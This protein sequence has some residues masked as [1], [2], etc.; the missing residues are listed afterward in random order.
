[1]SVKTSS[2]TGA[3]VTR[4]PRNQERRRLAAARGQ[5]RG[6]S[7]PPAAAEAGVELEHVVRDTG[8][9]SWITP[10]RTPARRPRPPARRDRPRS[11]T[12]PRAAA[13]R[14]AERPARHPLDGAVEL[15][16][17]PP[18]ADSSREDDDCRLL[19]HQQR[20]SPPRSGG[21]PRSPPRRRTRRRGRAA[22]PR[23]PLGR[24][25]VV[26]RQSRARTA[27]RPCAGG[28]DDAAESA[29]HSSLPPDDLAD[30]V[31]SDVETKHDRV[32]ALLGLD[33]D[34]VGLVDEPPRKPLEE[35]S[36]R[37]SADVDAR[38]P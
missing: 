11:T 25:V 30:V 19:V 36:H 16:R 21:H 22:A 9:T 20:W 29:C 17:R 33:A 13:T 37:R 26:S 2:R 7:P 23:A 15:D 1:M 12:L 5:H 6:R 18:T 27:L 10:R 28:A 34:G 8:R 35:L 3:E 38:R 32:L 31:R 4:G 14:P 24:A